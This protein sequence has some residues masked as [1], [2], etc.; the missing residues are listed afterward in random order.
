MEN[1]SHRPTR[2]ATRR[3][4]GS[5]NTTTAGKDS[6]AVHAALSPEQTEGTILRMAGVL[7]ADAARH[8]SAHKEHVA[9]ISGALALATSVGVLTDERA[10]EVRRAALALFEAACYPEREYRADPAFAAM[11]SAV[12]KKGGASVDAP[13]AMAE[14]GSTAAKAMLGRLM[15][16]GIV[17]AA[18]A[19]GFHPVIAGEC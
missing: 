14:L 2:A 16:A 1:R 7:S 11:V 8:P 3:S 12:R 4:Q 9:Y 18:D 17:G 5:W 19:A 6:K 15:A 10:L 13:L